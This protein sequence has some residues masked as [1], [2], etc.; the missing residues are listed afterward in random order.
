MMHLFQAD[1]EMLMEEISAQLNLG[2]TVVSDR[3]FLSTY[4]YQTASAGLVG[5]ADAAE[6][7]IQACNIH[8]LVPALTIILEVPLEVA[9][10][11]RRSRAVTEDHYERRLAFMQAVHEGYAEVQATSI[12][13]V[14]ANREKE[15]V[16]AEVFS[17][18]SGLLG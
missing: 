16:A 7:L 17:L 6:E 8:T 9:I 5:E 1:R 18:V 11:R 12:V 15:V 2:R 4:I 3:N 13:R 10:E 14:D